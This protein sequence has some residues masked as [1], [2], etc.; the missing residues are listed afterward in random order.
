[1][2]RRINSIILHNFFRCDLG[3]W[4]G[5]NN[6]LLIG[7][8][9]NSYA[10]PIGHHPYRCRLAGEPHFFELPEGAVEQEMKEFGNVFGCG[11]VLDLD[12]NLTIFFTLN[13][14]LMGMLLREILRTD[15]KF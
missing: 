14:K 13:G 9:S 12:N 2:S 15:K 11:L 7:L 3:L 5:A 1:M 8:N 4:G 6:N 10:I